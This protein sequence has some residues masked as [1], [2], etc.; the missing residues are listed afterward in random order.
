MQ[1]FKIHFP[2]Y[3]QVSDIHNDNMDLHV[4]LEDGRVFFGTFFTLQNI[5]DLMT[6]NRTVYFWAEDMVVVE[7]LSRETIRKVVRQI[8]NDEYIDEALSFIGTITEIYS[9]KF[10]F[11]EV[12]DLCLV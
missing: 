2:V 8:I 5:Q 7:D 10:S 4:V 6:K 12:V 3:Y 11:E 9:D 1:N